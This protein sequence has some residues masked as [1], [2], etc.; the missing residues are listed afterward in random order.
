M[1]IQNPGIAAGKTLLKM[2]VLLVSTPTAAYDTNSI[3]VRDERGPIKLTQ[4]DD[5]PTAT[6]KYR[7]WEVDRDTVGDVEISYGAAPRQVSSETRNGPLFDLRAQGDGLMGAGVY[8]FAI[9]VSERPYNISLKW[10]MSEAPPSTRGIWS[11][12]EGEQHTVAPASTLEFSFYTVGPVK[13]E[14]ADGKGDFAMYWL[15]QPPFDI[16]QLAKSIGNLYVYM[17][18]FFEDKGSPYRVFVRA[19]PYPAGGGTAAWKSFMFAFGTDGKTIAEGPQMLIAHEMAHN[20]PK[21]DGGEENHAGTAWYTEG[22]AEYYS[23]VLSLRAGVIG[24]DKFLSVINSHASDYYGNPFVASTNRQAGEKFWTDAR[25][26]RVPYG[27]GF[28]Y[29]AKVNEEIR[30]KSD[31]K[32]SLDMLVLKVLKRQRAGGKF[33]LPDWRSLI[34]DEVGPNAATEY[35]EMV[36]GKLI[37]PPQGT[38]GPCFEVVSEPE[39]P[40]DL[41]FDEMRLGVVKNLREDSA[42]AKAGVHEGDIIVSLTPLDVVRQDPTKKMDLK[43]KRGG[44]EITVTYSPREPEVPAWHWVRNPAVDQKNCGI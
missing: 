17:S 23:A 33:G 43:L 38:F 4:V 7:H 5:E 15:M 37:V 35:D 32:R 42:A 20:W 2:P 3:T 25:A 26:Q 9:P 22:T 27:R 30:A 6:G 16:D 24:L 18:G 13:S 36:A 8:F 12:G 14:P 29:L 34:I 19:N 41:G 39:Q 40:F 31:G 44:Q 21:F 11:A 28:M 10:D 1:R